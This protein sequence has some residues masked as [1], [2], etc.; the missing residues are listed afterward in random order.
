MTS[1]STETHLD[2]VILVKI[3]T[4][5]FVSNPLKNTY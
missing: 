5:R 3:A 1:S 2:S 4:Y